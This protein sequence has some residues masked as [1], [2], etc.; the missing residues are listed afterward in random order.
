MARHDAGPPFGR[1]PAFRRRTVGRAGAYAHTLT[2]ARLGSWALWWEG[3]GTGAG[4]G[5]ASGALVSW[6]AC[7]G[8]WGQTQPPGFTPKWSGG[9]RGWCW[10]CVLLC[11]AARH[12]QAA[13]P[14]G[15]LGARPHLCTLPA[16][17]R[18]A[19]GHRR[20]TTHPVVPPHLLHRWPALALAG[21]PPQ[22]G[23]PTHA[24]GP[25]PLSSQAHPEIVLPPVRFHPHNIFRR[26]HIDFCWG[27]K[28]VRSFKGPLVASF[29]KVWRVA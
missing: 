19:A 4:E 12:S 2:F 3:G 8:L 25:V 14:T 28:K 21:S 1:R 27:E 18:L 29:Q 20:P 6:Q 26:Y 5:S 9:G 17:W 10:P 7:D 15:R 23:L 24:R 22:A 11:A 16:R 13:R